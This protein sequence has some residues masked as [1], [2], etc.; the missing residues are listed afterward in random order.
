MMGDLEYK[1]EGLIKFLAQRNQESPQVYDTG[2]MARYEE[3]QYD[4][5]F[6]ILLISE[7]SLLLSKADSSC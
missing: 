7:F 5:S 6:L 2:E 1:Q 3:E 4:R